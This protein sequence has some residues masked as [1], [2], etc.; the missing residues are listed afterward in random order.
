MAAAWLL[1]RKHEVVLFERDP[2]LGGHTHT[3]VVMHEGREHRV[4][5]GFIVFNETN[6]PLFSRFLAELGVA[7]KPTT[8]SFSVRNE[9]TGVEYAA[10]NLDTLFCQRRNLVSRPFVRM[11]ADLA[12]FYRESPRLLARDD[13]GPSIGEYLRESGYS[14]TFA[15][16]HL[17]PMASALWSSPTTRI[18]DFPAKFLVRFMDNHRMLHFFDRP[19]WRVVEGG[20][21]RY[22]E[23][24]RASWDVT[25]RLD[26]AVRRVVRTDDGVEVRTEDTS[27]H[28]DHVVLAC[29]TDQA[30]AILEAPTEREAEILG[31]VPYQPNEVILHTDRRQLPRARKAWSAWNAVVPTD[32]RAS[33]SVSYCMSLLQD[34]DTEEPF[35]VTLNPTTPIAVDKVLA[36]MRYSHP[37][38]THASVEALGRVDE[39]D[40]VDRISYAGAHWGYGFHE[41]GFASGVRV[42]K[43]LGA[44][45]T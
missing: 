2:R 43:K 41:D 10:T 13:H 30:L 32:P 35:V 36:R 8:M 20:S 9:R 28:F 17:I 31:A 11:V 39:I 26:A 15:E 38:Y 6:Y 33:C 12:R 27:E 14:A 34:L 40:G 7:S 24:L 42:A 19:A 25:V 29:H 44:P 23:A 18:H 45:W 21:S 3:H 37:V 5:T 4:D 1:A 22:V 16:D